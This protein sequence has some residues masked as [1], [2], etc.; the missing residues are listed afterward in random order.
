MHWLLSTN[1][2]EIGTLYLIFAAFAGMMGIVF[3]VYIFYDNLSTIG[4]I[5]SNMVSVEVGVQTEDLNNTVPGLDPNHNTSNTVE[6]YEAGVQTE[7]LDNT[8]PDLDPISEIPQLETPVDEPNIPDQ[9]PIQGGVRTL[10]DSRV[11]E[12]MDNLDP[13][14]SVPADQIIDD[15]TDSNNH[16]EIEVS[17]LIYDDTEIIYDNF[18]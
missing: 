10:N 13:L 9:Q 7:D 8:V 14:Q 18:D 11:E 16:P 5:S 15:G 1:A 17:D 4:H 6:Y 2:K 3:C 12:W